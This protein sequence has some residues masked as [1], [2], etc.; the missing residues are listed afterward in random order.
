[1][2]TSIKHRSTFEAQDEV[3]LGIEFR[4]IFVGLGTLVGMESPSKIDRETNPIHDVKRMRQDSPKAPREIT[5]AR[6]LTREYFPG[7]PGEKLWKNDIK[8]QK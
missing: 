5:V 3:S 1:M 4:W 6:K 7:G 2:P 8:I